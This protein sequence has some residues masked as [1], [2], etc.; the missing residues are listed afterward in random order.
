[1]VTL[2]SRL[3]RLS[4]YDR[5]KQVVPDDFQPLMPPPPGAEKLPA[6]AAEAAA[7]DVAVPAGDTVEAVQTAAASQL[8]A[9]VG[10]W[11]VSCGPHCL[12]GSCRCVSLHETQVTCVMRSCTCHMLATSDPSIPPPKPH[13]PASLEHAS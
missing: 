11:H 13:L 7:T 3:I 4:Y 5:V 6:A 2:M 10:T 9:K 1:M 8:L 12:A